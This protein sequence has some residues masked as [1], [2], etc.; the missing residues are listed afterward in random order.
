[1]ISLICFQ[2]LSSALGSQL[3]SMVGIWKREILCLCCQCVNGTY[4]PMEN[5]LRTATTA[6]HD[7]DGS[8]VANFSFVLLVSLELHT[9]PVGSSL[10]ECVCVCIVRTYQLPTIAVSSSFRIAYFEFKCNRPYHLSSELAVVV[11]M[12]VS[13]AQTQIAIHISVWWERERQNTKVFVCFGWSLLKQFRWRRA[14]MPFIRF[15]TRRMPPPD[16]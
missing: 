11:P 9:K 6:R 15:E 13:R 16:Q 14:I 10:C 1:M 4:L 3:I 8:A 2:W 7:Q 12:S 5:C